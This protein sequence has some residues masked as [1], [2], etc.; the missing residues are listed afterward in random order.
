MRTS[1]GGI[2]RGSRGA[3]WTPANLTN[4]VDYWLGDAAASITSSAGKV[5]AWAGLR[6]VAT[7]QQAS[8]PSQPS[9]GVRTL[10][11]LNVIDFTAANEMT[12]AASLGLAQPY[13]VWWVGTMDDFT[14]VDFFRQIGSTEAGLDAAAVGTLNAGTPQGDGHQHTTYPTV[15][16]MVFNGASS[17]IYDH[18]TFYACAGSVGANAL[19]QIT[20]HPNIGAADA[21]GVGMVAIQNAAP[22]AGDLTNMAAYVARWGL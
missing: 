6:S 22:T 15:I 14:Q 5:S 2:R 12:L 10:N 11:G 4:P 20:L 1:P 3:G 19:G 13:T 17:G 8:G 18:G 16:G 21:G 9:T 7:W